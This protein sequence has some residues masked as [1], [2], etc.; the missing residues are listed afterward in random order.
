[1]SENEILGKEHLYKIHTL[2]MVV[3]IHA[4]YQFLVIKKYDFRRNY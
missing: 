4:T 3:N 2:F 1:M